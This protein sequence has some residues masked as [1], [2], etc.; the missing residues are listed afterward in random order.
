MYCAIIVR[1]PIK[2]STKECVILSR[3]V[4]LGQ[5]SCRTKV[6][7]IF[8]IS[9]PDFSRIVLRLFPEFLRVLRASFRGKRK[10]QKIHQRSPLFFNTKSPGKHKK[11]VHI[12]LERGKAKHR[13]IW[14][15]S[16]LGLQAFNLAN[17]AMTMF[18]PDSGPDQVQEE[19]LG[20]SCSFRQS[21][22]HP[23]P[24]SG[25]FQA[26]VCGVMVFQF[27]RH[28]GNQRPKCL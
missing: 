4:S 15:V 6:P 14:E 13:A 12:F 10:P 16:L 27:S 11:N 25:E 20:L 22:L 8:W 18:G 19:G 23:A 21:Y 3:Q 2:T 1:Y 26:T 28:K 7:Q 9:V 17:T 5:K 24:L